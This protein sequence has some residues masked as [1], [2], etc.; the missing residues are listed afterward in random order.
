MLVKLTKL[1]NGTVLIICE[2]LFLQLSSMRNK[3]VNILFS[4]VLILS[5]G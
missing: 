3:A 1:I 4:F 2:Y 5:L